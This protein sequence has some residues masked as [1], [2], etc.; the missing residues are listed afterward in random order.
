VIRTADAIL[1]ELRGTGYE[2]TEPGGPRRVL[3]W[4]DPPPRD[5]RGGSRY[6]VPASKYAPLADEL[7]AHPGRWALIYVGEK[8][9]ATSIARVIS[10]GQ[11]PVM[12]FRDYEA[13]TRT[14][15]GQTR[16]YARYIGEA[17]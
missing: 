7:K 9:K 6:P 2:P 8:A 12:A 10:L 3:R 5:L 4:E 14:A 16:V 1:A 11:V 15:D 17:G 13:V